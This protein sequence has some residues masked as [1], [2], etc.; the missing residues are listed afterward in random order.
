MTTATTDMYFNMYGDGAVSAKVRG[1]VGDLKKL[2]QGWKKYT[3]AISRGAGAVSGGSSGSGSG[4]GSGS[5]L[6][7][8]AVAT[9]VVEKILSDKAYEFIKNE[10]LTTKEAFKVSGEAFR[11]FGKHFT[12]DGI[13]FRKAFKDIAK[14]ISVNTGLSSTIKAIKKNIGDF[15]IGT[16]DYLKTVKINGKQFYDRIGERFIEVRQLG[17]LIAMGMRDNIKEISNIFGGMKSSISADASEIKMIMKNIGISLGID[18][19]LLKNIGK[20][21]AKF[22]TPERAKKFLEH[23][24]MPWMAVA[25]KPLFS[26]A[27]QIGGY[28]A[29]LVR[30]IMPVLKI[31]GGFFGTLAAAIIATDDRIAK[32]INWL[33]EKISKVAEKTIGFVAKTLE[34]IKNGAATL[35]NWV[36]RI[37]ENVTGMDLGSEFSVGRFSSANEKLDKLISPSQQQDW[38]RKMGQVY[39]DMYGVKARNRM[40]KE[41]I[42]IVN[43]SNAERF[44]A[45]LDL[46][47]LYK[48]GKRV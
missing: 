7:G 29:T 38:L 4:G 45:M 44:K 32:G 21:F 27:R 33:M 43:N 46:E 15:R 40:K 19:K 39:E 28:V 3:S 12:I 6:M 1:V 5:A 17:S 23:T 42:D 34:A 18:A 36:K 35:G 14:K 10:L 13:G 2:E 37:G 9:K 26:G 41:L 8:M 31:A 16:W 11:Q 22:Y 20:T 25:I 47:Y 30:G 48:K 24:V